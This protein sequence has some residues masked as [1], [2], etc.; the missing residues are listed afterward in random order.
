MKNLNEDASRRTSFSVF[1]SI[2]IEAAENQTITGKWQETEI[3]VIEEADKMMKP[4]L[5]VATR[6]YVRCW[7][8]HRILLILI[9][10]PTKCLC[11][12]SPSRPVP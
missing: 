4:G 6:R 8:K 7:P 11:S 5:A 3:R 2:E 1:F 10:W 12:G 9:Y